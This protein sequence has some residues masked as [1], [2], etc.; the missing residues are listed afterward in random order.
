MIQFKY[1]TMTQGQLGILFGVSSHVIGKWLVELNLRS[2]DKQPTREA[3]QDG[4][5]EKAPSGSMGY[6]WV[7][8]S[9]KT[10]E[11]LIA[12][13]HELIVDL[14]EDLVEASPLAGPF[15]LSEANMRDVLDHDGAIAVRA[16]SPKTAKIVLRL[17]VLADRSGVL[18]KMSANTPGKA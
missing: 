12:A 3:H 10:V 2:D 6:H 8:R 4:Y 1:K 18:A 15:R 11:R 17:L 7:W 9:E 5:C 13:G 16:A 14:P